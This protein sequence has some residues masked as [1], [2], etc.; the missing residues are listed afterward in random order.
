MRHCI[1]YLSGFYGELVHSAS[2]TNGVKV[3][4]NGKSVENHARTN[5][6]MSELTGGNP[7]KTTSI[8]DEYVTKS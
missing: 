4:V 8:G 3:I 2:F 5:T 1:A 7:R 6:M